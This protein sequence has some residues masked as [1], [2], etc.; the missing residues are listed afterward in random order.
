[1]KIKPQLSAL[2]S[3]VGI[4]LL[5]LV[6]VFAA[7]NAEVVTINFLIWEF[8]MSRAIMIFLLLLIGF[9]VGRLYKGMRRT[10]ESDS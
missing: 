6:V 9:L 7:Q 3:Y 8:S 4:F 2:K 10:D 5:F 1:M